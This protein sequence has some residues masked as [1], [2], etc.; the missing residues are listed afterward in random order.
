MPHGEH[1]AN[2]EESLTV[3]G[4]E[5]IEDET[6]GLVVE[7]SE[8]VGHAPEDM[9]VTACISSGQKPTD[10]P[11]SSPRTATAGL[12]LL[13]GCT[14]PTA[15]SSQLSLISSCAHRV[16]GRRRTSLAHATV[17]ALPHQV[18]VPAVPGVLLDPVHQQFP[19]GN[20]VPPQTL[21]QIWMLGQRGVS[22][23]LLAGQVGICGVDQRLIGESSVEVRVANAVELRPR[24]TRQEP[25]APRPTPR[26]S[27]AGSVG[28]WSGSLA[29]SAVRRPD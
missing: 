12:P 21:P 3:P 27:S 23:R 5:F 25:A 1:G 18:G 26:T 29:A 16:N 4:R 10:G 24:V 22:G 15:S 9:Q 8:H 13:A 6:P 14:I 7:S 19:D 28:N 2:L 17:D 11:T 20:A